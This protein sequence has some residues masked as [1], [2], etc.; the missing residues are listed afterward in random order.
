[1]HRHGTHRS[2]PPDDLHG[3]LQDDPCGAS[4]SDTSRSGRWVVPW[5]SNVVMLEPMLSHSCMSACQILVQGVAGILLVMV[6]AACGYRVARANDA[7]STGSLA[8]STAP[9]PSVHVQAEQATLLLTRP[10]VVLL[11]VGPC[12]GC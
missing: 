4:I 5:R 11:Q 10:A 1:M 3:L 2:Y 6:L 7:R 9:S 12:F 8:L